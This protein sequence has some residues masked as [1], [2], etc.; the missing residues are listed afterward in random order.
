MRFEELP[1]DLRETVESLKHGSFTIECDVKDALDNA[2]NLQDFKVRA[3][4]ALNNLINEARDAIR[5]LSIGQNPHR[6]LIEKERD[7][8]INICASGPLSYIRKIDDELFKLG[9]I[10]WWDDCV[11]DAVEHNPNV[12]F[13]SSNG[14]ILKEWYDFSEAKGAGVR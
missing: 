3:S 5:S 6:K 13:Y 8:M 4:G 2:E 7:R 1:S 9:L 11:M 10:V 12:P 14:R